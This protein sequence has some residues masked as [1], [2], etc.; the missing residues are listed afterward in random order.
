MPS[1]KRY[2]FDSDVLIASWN[3][4]YKP[5]F[6]PEFWDWIDDGYAHEIF[7][8][9]DKVRDELLAGSPPAAFAKWVRRDS[10][11]SF[12]L[13][14]LVG[15]QRWQAL[16]DWARD[17]KLQFKEAAKTKFLDVKSADAWLIAFAAHAG[18]FDIVSNEKSEPASKKDI[19][20]PDA[21]GALG[22]QT[23]LLHELLSRHAGPHF[24][25]RK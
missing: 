17:P 11:K 6:C 12:Y 10:K 18:N 16:S 23:L 3:L 7:F 4:T 5:D 8:S 15:M 19:K 13:D 20:L 25:F 22:V 21:A 1:C 9:I 14:S 2:L 24:R